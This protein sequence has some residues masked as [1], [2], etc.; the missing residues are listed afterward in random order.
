M[1]EE[2]TP[3]EKLARAVTFR[4]VSYGPDRRADPGE[5]KRLYAWL[6]RA[7]PRVHRSL[8]LSLLGDRA[9]LYRW[10]GG[11]PE[12][13]A[14]LCVAHTDVVP[15]GTEEAGDGPWTHPPFS[16]AVADGWVWGRG[17]LDNK[18]AVISLLQAVEELLEE[19]FSP[20]RTLYLAFGADEEIDGREG[21][22]VIA[23]HLGERGVALDCILD[24]GGV[25][26]QDFL[27]GT[28]RPVALIG[29][30][31]KGQFAL[32]LSV[33]A[34]GGH[35]AMPPS[36]TAAGILAEAVARLESHPMPARL[37]PAVARFLGD[38]AGVLRGPRRWLF[39]NLWLSR[40]LVLASM[41]GSPETAAVVR[42]TRAPTMLQGSEK[43]NVLPRTARAVIN[44]RLLPGDSV[45]SVTER[46]RDLFRGRRFRAEDG[47]PAV[48]VRVLDPAA[49]NEAIPESPLP[50]AAYDNLLAALGRVYPEAQPVPFVFTMATDSRH[51]RELC[52]AIYRFQAVLLQRAD[53][54]RI[55][56]TDER[57]S[58][59]GLGKLVEFYR[60]FIR[61]HCGKAGS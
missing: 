54:E 56:G 7:F 5:L 37:T 29:V 10:P 52:R 58:V 47:T 24:E 61:A 41:A 40:P 35:A 28:E 11:D 26:F 14:A 43:E 13:G 20:E 31:E 60:L 33:A 55:H 39:R 57:I 53:L 25:I 18:H 12:L 32:E 4:T 19:G 30:A 21:A 2:S 44:V 8:E 59:E 6:Q 23:A 16:G 49:A 27:P 22:R 9:A 15:A 48:Q 3:A 42:T 34:P 46:T 36:R 1:N 51:Y 38:L 50:S 17:T 45:A